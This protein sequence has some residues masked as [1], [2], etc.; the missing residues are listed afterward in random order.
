MLSG[1]G[2]RLFDAAF[3]RYKGFRFQIR[4][5][6]VFHNKR[7]IAR[8]RA[9]Q[10]QA[11]DG[12]GFILAR[13]RAV[14]GSRRRHGQFVALYKAVKGYAVIIQRRVR[15]AIVGL[16][17]RRKSRNRYGLFGNCKR[18]RRRGGQLVIRVAQRRRRGD[19]GSHGGL[20]AC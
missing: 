5:R 1:I 10:R 9:A 17:V 2:V 3:R 12:N 18:L 15:R 13:V 7:I 6:T 20:F 19:I 4:L 11:A 8:V 14:K 16:I